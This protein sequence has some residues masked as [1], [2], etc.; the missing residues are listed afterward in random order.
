MTEFIKKFKI[1]ILIFL[2]FVLIRLPDLGHDVFNTDVW[3]WKSRTYDFGTGVFTLDFEKTL[4]KY[5]PG[6]S[7]MWL[8]VGGVKVNSFYHKVILGAPP[9]D[10][11]V[12][13]IFKLH[14]IQ[15]TIIV[16]ALGVLVSVLYHQLNQLFGKTY[17]MFATALIVFEPFNVALTRVMHLEGLMSIFM[18]LSFVFIFRY[19]VD[20]RSTYLH[21]SAV[22]AAL[23]FLTKTSSLFL[24]PFV[25]MIVYIE[26]IKGSFPLKEALKLATVKYIK[27]L[28]VATLIF[29][30]LWPVMYVNPALAFETLKRGIFTIGIERA[31]AQLFLNRWVEDPGYLFYLIAL[32]FRA[33]LPVL[34][35]VFGFFTLSNKPLSTAKRKWFLLYCFA[36]IVFY[37][38]ELTIPSKKL[39]RYVLPTLLVM[40]FVASFYYEYV[41][42][43][44]VKKVK[45]GKWALI[46][47]I[48]A[49]YVFT[50]TQL[51]PNYFSYYSPLF[52]GLRTGIY[53]IEPKWMLGQEE[54]VEHFSTSDIYSDF[55]KFEDGESLDEYLNTPEIENM[56]TIGFPEKYYTQIW[57]FIAEIGGRA[58][59]EDITAMAEKTNF[60]VYPV[61]DDINIED[62]LDLELVSTI[63]LRGVDLYHVYRR[64]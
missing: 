20:Y 64:L 42:D 40:V 31:H 55:Q 28:G 1:E 59:I 48:I 39:D 17:S 60:F 46:G 44:I 50:L 49:Y 12:S 9:A 29:I 62:R 58:S 57:P 51:H 33:S 38:I 30:V 6:V 35:G 15:K 3:K 32:L 27:W 11:L 10:N 56:L 26:H 61:Y 7:L 22:F 24:I 19:F 36:F 18:L 21:F 13:N 52:G 47:S 37:T 54:I 45:L 43:N 34:I 25:A 16:L 23:A 53:A 8:G 5:H 4:Q 41:F 14:A 2:V 63:K